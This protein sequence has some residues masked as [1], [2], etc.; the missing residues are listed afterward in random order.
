MRRVFCPGCWE[1]QRKID[2][3]LEENQRLKAQLRY[4][5]RQATEGFFGSAT[6][7]A[8]RPVKANS[9]AEQQAKRG[10]APPGH[11]GHGRRALHAATAARVL[12]VP[13]DP[14]CPECGGPL[15]AKGCRPRSVL[16]IAPPRPEPILYR[17][18]RGYC[19]RCRRAVQAPLPAVLPKALFGNE[20]TAHLLC[21]PTICMGSP[22]AGSAPS[23]ASGSAA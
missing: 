21:L 12:D 18:E 20:L 7:S 1:K 8:Q 3:L 19:P 5:Q 15:E 22:W 11:P 23:W 16:D 13:V 4:R 10:G 14:V 6:P 2:A 9:P 17:L